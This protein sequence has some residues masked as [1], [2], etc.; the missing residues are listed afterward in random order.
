ME[1]NDVKNQI[2]QSLENIGVTGVD[3]ITEDFNLNEIIVDSVMFISFMIDLE[4]SFML[5]I[6]DRCLRKETLSSLSNLVNT[7]MQIQDT[8]DEEDDEIED[9]KIEL[10]NIE[11]ETEQ[12]RSKWFSTDSEEERDEIELEI[13]DNEC[14]IEDIKCMIQDSLDFEDDDDNI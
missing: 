7:I 8:P 12:L 2:L 11:Q 6:P 5:Q 10:E 14:I 13:N 4:D 1:K 3:D 9:L